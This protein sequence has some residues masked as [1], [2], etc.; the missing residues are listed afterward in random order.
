MPIN[1]DVQRPRTFNPL[2][3]PPPLVSAFALVPRCFWYC[4]ALSI[5]L[6]PERDDFVLLPRSL[7]KEVVRAVRVTW[8]STFSREERGS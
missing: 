5:A 2:P 6:E 7:E 4:Y 1:V 8:R 3:L